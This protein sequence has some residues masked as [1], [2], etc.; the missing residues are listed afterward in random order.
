[1]KAAWTVHHK[2]YEWCVK[3]KK[4]SN[5]EELKKLS[6]YIE[7][8]FIFRK[9]WLSVFSSW[10]K[11]AFSCMKD[12]TA[13][14]FFLTRTKCTRSDWLRGNNTHFQL[15]SSLLTCGNF[16]KARGRAAKFKE[17]APHASPSL[18]PSWETEG[19]GNL[20]SREGREQGSEFI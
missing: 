4:K 20:G 7:K 1:M 9:I 13:R 14:S 17:I 19:K 6:M 12:D 16:P 11:P 2:M 15:S 18:P 3:R 8:C 10:L 5:T